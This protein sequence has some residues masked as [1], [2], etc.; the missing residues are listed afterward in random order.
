M[1]ESYLKTH[2]EKEL[3]RFIT[4][5]SVDDGKSTLIGRLLYDTKSLFSDQIATLQKDSRKNAEGNLD[6]ALLVDG[7]SSEREQGITIDV[8]YRFFTSNRRK[9]IIADTPGHEQ[10]T[11]NMATGAS[12]ADIAIILIDA[13]KGVLT[14]TKRHSYIVSLLGIRHIIVAINKM[15]LVSYDEEVFNKICR[16][17]KE[18]LPFLHNDIKTYFIPICALSGENVVKTEVFNLNYDD[19]KHSVDEYEKVMLSEKI[20]FQNKD[21]S[22]TPQNDTFNVMLSGS[23]T[24]HGN[25]TSLESTQNKDSSYSFRMTQNL[26]STQNTKNLLWYKG[27]SLLELLDTI[28]LD[29]DRD[30][31]FIMPT[32]LVNRPHLN[33]RAF[34]GTIAS[35]NISLNDEIIALPS[36]QKARVKSIITSDIKDLRALGKDEIAESQNLAK[37]GMSVSLC[38]D[39]EIDIARGD[40]LAF[41]N[42]TLRISKTFKAMIIC[43]DSAGLVCN[44]EYLIKRAHN[45]ERVKIDI[46]YHK[47]I[48]TFKQEGA[49][50]LNLNDIAYCTLR[51]NKI[52]ALKPYKENKILGSFIIIDK[53]SNQT[54]AAGMIDEIIDEDFKQIDSS[55]SSQ[56]DIIESHNDKA[57]S[58]NNLPCND[59]V[60]CKS[61]IANKDNATKRIYTDAEIALN[62]FIREHYP[63]WGCKKI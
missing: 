18:I 62:A 43:M 20:Y 51:L 41:T 3:C 39:R 28:E 45:L 7:L 22:A 4:C 11:R 57:K 50:R 63:E 19:L 61:N 24:S 52:L 9:F 53:Y 25:K 44:E 2:E 27:K 33:F 35:G 23:E 10:Y 54:L 5:G 55:T 21:S 6:F 59:E 60:Y 26:N 58:Q 49:D 38:L 31:E 56:N 15:D 12:T 46:E 42:H 29:S 36:M 37:S 14:Q 40:I 32:Q 8:A 48:N 16:D 34:C 30:N 47:D 1:I 13:R 17:Y